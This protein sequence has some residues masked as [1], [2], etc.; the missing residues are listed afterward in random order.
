[1]HTEG[2]LAVQFEK[3]WPA[4]QSE[5]LKNRGYAVTTAPS[6]TVS[7]VGIADDVRKF[8]AAMR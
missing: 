1:M 4:S 8:V 7:A 2:M 6:A 5:E 3:N